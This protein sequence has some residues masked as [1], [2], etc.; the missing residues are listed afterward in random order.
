VQHLLEPNTK[1]TACACYVP[2]KWR[3]QRIKTYPEIS[4]SSEHAPQWDHRGG[5]NLALQKKERARSKND[6]FE[7]P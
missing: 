6:R 7:I 2:E 1:L 5:Q 4:G 3:I